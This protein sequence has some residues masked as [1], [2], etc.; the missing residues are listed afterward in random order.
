MEIGQGSR[1][2]IFKKQDFQEARF[3][4]SKVQE[5][6]FKKQGSRFKVQEARARRRRKGKR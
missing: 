4:R 1:S 3:S 2:K 5:A 6:R